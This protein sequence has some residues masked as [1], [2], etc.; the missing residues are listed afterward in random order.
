MWH[1]SG[2]RARPRPV[3]PRPAPVGA[4][5][6]RHPRGVP[7]AARALAPEGGKLAHVFQP[8]TFTV[9]QRANCWCEPDRDGP[10]RSER[11]LTAASAPA[12]QAGE[13]AAVLRHRRLHRPAL[14][15]G[16]RAHLAR[17]LAARRARRRFT[18]APPPL[19]L[20]SALHR[21][22]RT[23]AAVLG[24]AALTGCLHLGISSN[25]RYQLVNGIEVVLYSRLPQATAR[26][27][28]VAIRVANNFAGAR[29]WITA[30]S[31]VAALLGAR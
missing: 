3:P 23:A 4:A 1:S 15:G 9:A 18:R 6:C 13:V 26:A 24:R 8:G 25:T 16:H 30:S 28:S 31:L 20:T 19:T 5:V 2:A 10:P 7:R 11:L 27:G 22:A 14:H 12:L 29:L 21:G 17:Q